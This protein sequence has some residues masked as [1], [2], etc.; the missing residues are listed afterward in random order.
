[1]YIIFI[2][3]K[4]VFPFKCVESRDFKAAFVGWL[5]RDSN[6]RL[7][8]NVSIWVS[9]FPYAANRILVLSASDGGK[10]ERLRE[11]GLL[12]LLFWESGPP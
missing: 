1:M 3:V 2:V 8:R 7:Q 4:L 12:I 11:T 10:E 9:I 6:G 5:E